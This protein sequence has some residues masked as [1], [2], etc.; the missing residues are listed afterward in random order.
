M[1]GLSGRG[2]R[3]SYSSAPPT[4]TAPR[5]SWPP[6]PR[7]RT[8]RAYCDEQHAL[9]RDVGQAFGLSWDWFGRS[10]S[11]ENRAL[12]QH[13]ADVLE[14]HGLIEERTDRMIYSIETSASCLTAM[15]KE[16]VPSAATA[17]RGGIKC[18]NCGLAPRPHRPDRALLRRLWLHQP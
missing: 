4:S 3:R 7:D 10:S 9:Q 5:P 14:D 1:A 11:L 13:F 12:T 17:Q 16:P 15:W 6:P 18:D 8:L 2:A